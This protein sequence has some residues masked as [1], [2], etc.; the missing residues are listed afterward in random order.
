MQLD[1]FT[2]DENYWRVKGAGRLILVAGLLLLNL[3]AII[4]GI[5]LLLKRIAAER[6]E[7]EGCD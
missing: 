1:Y 2:T 6:R 5:G 7:A 3:A 4:Y